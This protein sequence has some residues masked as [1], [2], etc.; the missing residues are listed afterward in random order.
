MNSPPPCDFRALQAGLS[1]AGALVSPSEAQ[2]MAFG[3]VFAR[4]K[5]AAVVWEYQLLCEV[6]PAAAVPQSCRASLG[7][8]YAEVLRQTEAGELA[9][10]LCLPDADDASLAERATALRDWCGGFLFGIG[11]AGQSIHRELR[12]DAREVLRDLSEI[13]KLDTAAVAAGEADEVALVELEE[14]V[15]VAALLVRDE[16]QAGSG[17]NHA[18]E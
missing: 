12:D 6:E 7:E 5:E 4:V 2:G 14:Y 18:P 9:L 8:L 15:R 10:R 3:L 1:A 11:L 13:S 17:S 16:L